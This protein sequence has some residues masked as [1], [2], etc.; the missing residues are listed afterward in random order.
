AV[1]PRAPRHSAPLCGTS[2][3]PPVG[4]ALSSPPADTPA[5][6]TTDFRGHC[7]AHGGTRRAAAGPVCGG[8]SALGGSVDARTAGPA[9][10]PGTNGRHLDLGDVSPWVS[11]A[12][13]FAAVFY[14]S[15]TAALTPFSSGG[16]D[17]AD[18]RRDLPPAGSQAAHC[19]QHRWC[20][21]VCGR[22]DQ[23]GAGVGLAAGAGGAL[24]ADWSPAPLGDSR[25]PPR[26]VDGQAGPPGPG[27]SHCATGGDA[28]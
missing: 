17:R 7:G 27:E 1:L 23:D 13:G 15:S 14:L 22:V 10:D 8:R 3:T 9:D 16:N 28:R 19:D 24:C 26:L 6:A 25:D 5:A 12:L 2:H 21:P 18:H 20:P 4:G 11:V